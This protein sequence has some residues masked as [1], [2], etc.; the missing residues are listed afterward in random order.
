MEDK[1]INLEFVNV[2]EALRYLGYGSNEPD[3]NMKELL[4]LC[5]KELLKNVH[6][7]YVFKVFDL[8]DEC[9]LMNCDFTLQGNDIKRHLE[10]C[11]KAV[12]MCVTLSSDVDRLIRIKQIGNMAQATIIDSMAS[13]LVEQA[14]DQVEKMIKEELPGY[15]FTWRYGLGY[16]DFPLEGQKQFLNVLDAQKKVGVCVS[17]SFMLTPTKSVTCIIGAGR[18]KVHEEKRSCEFCNLQGRCQYRKRGERCG[19]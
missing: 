6:P 11:E 17:D 10:N 19:N 9:N 3:P 18:E 14:C 8:D 13:A 2:S 7:N 15:R 4:S 12:L 16:G 1:R 5:E